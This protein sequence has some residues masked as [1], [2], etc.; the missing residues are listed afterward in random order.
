MSPL[1]VLQ[2]I[3]FQYP[4]PPPPKMTW[5]RPSRLFKLQ[6]GLASVLQIRLI[7]FV[8]STSGTMCQ[9]YKLL[10]SLGRTLNSMGDYHDHV[11]FPHDNACFRHVQLFRNE[12]HVFL[13]VITHSFECVIPVNENRSNTIDII[14]LRIYLPWLSNT[15]S[16]GHKLIHS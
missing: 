8:V 14:L 10:H 12:L 5:S 9:P 7:R 16:Q 11:T 2:A 13:R 4:P 15:L 6:F 1:P 3:N